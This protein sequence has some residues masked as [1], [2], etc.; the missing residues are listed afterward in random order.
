MTA[1]THRRIALGNAA[2]ARREHAEAAEHYRQ[3]LALDPNLGHIWIQLGHMLKDAGDRHGAEVAY[4]RAVE[5]G[6]GSGEGW[7]HLGHLAKRSGS[8]HLAIRNYYQALQVEPTNADA[9]TELHRALGRAAG[10]ERHMITE[11]LSNALQAPRPA[12]IAAND[13]TPSTQVLASKAR[14]AL[15]T[16][17]ADLGSGEGAA[18]RDAVS[19]VATL[20]ERIATRD[21]GPAEGKAALVFDASDLIGYYGHARLPTGI[22]RVQI[23]AITSAI[24]E[25]ARAVHI[26]CFIDGRDDWLEWPIDQFL[27]ITELAVKSGERNDREWIAALNNLQ[28]TLALAEPFEFP[29]GAYLIN[30]GTSW[31]LHNYFL[32]VR[33]AKARHGIRYIPF[34]HDFIPIITPEHCVRGLTQDFITWALGVF[35]HADCFLV[36]SEAT[37]RDLLSVAR[38]LEKNVDPDDVAV[39]RLDADFRKPGVATLDRSSL[40]R[41]GLGDEPFVL[42]VS[43]IESRKG[44]VV[45]LDAWLELIRRH[46]RKAPKLVC[47]GKNGWLNDAVFQRLESSDEL[48]RRVTI[49]SYL[50]DEELSLLYRTCQFTIYPSLYE[51]WGLPVTEALCYGK[52]VVAA[53][54]SSLPEAGG[55]FAVYVEAGAVR[56]LADAAERMAFDAEWR[57]GW[58]AKIAAGFAPRNWRDIAAQIDHEAI[59]LAERKAAADGN[60]GFRPPEAVLGRWHPI[61]TNLETRIWT[62]AGTGEIFRAGLGW[63]WPTGDGCWTRPQGAELAIGLPRGHG[64]LRVYMLLWG[65]PEQECPWKLRIKGRPPLSGTLAPEEKKWISFDYPAADDDGV[66]RM[67]LNGQTAEAITMNTSGSEKEYFASLGVAGFFICDADD[68][69][70]RAALLE[71]AALGN[72]ADI[73]A[74]AERLPAPDAEAG[75]GWDEA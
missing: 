3:A 13:S 38:T 53:D 69:A 21:K 46:G 57:H 23:E 51:G 72:L 63:L 65:L 54:S 32:F 35:E 19:V 55:E 61:S 28:L 6:S 56:Q 45:A 27:S 66:L 50:S 7:L 8:M 42:F 41:W 2:R 11:F 75:D 22:Q 62:G 16:L 33:Q 67:R 10:H 73:S 58:E 31:W 40:A 52:A 15:E 37:K 20:E 43:T 12:P 34:V 36:N 48:K 39:I 68:G 70:A 14:R 18:I 17:A 59:R 74:Y 60:R 71:A 24:R 64:P 44:H 26:C 1:A 9:M 5:I 25:E 30:L 47:V 4:R 29:D 49:L